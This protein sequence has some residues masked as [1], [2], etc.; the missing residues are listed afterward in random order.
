MAGVPRLLQ[1]FKEDNLFIFSVSMGR[2]DAQERRRL[3]ARAPQI[4][5]ES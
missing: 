4:G 2:L 3:S 5:A 1:S